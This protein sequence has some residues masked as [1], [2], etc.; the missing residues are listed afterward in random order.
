MKSKQVTICMSRP[1]GSW[2]WK[3]NQSLFDKATGNAVLSGQSLKFPVRRGREKSKDVGDIANDRLWISET[4]LCFFFL[5]PVHM[6]LW[7]F[8]KDVKETVYS[9]GWCANPERMKCKSLLHPVNKRERMILSVA[10]LRGFPEGVGNNH[11]PLTGTSYTE[12]LWLH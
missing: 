9:L 4:S 3:K 1:R 6:C 7:I 2:I 8:R 11:R 10:L 5:I 12:I